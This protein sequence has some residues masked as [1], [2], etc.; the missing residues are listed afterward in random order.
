MKI[1]APVGE[2]RHPVQAVLR[3][4]GNVVPLVIE[5]EVLVGS[6]ITRKVLKRC[7]ICGLPTRIVDALA[8]K[9]NQ[10]AVTSK[11][12]LLI[13]TTIAIPYLDGRSVGCLP[14]RQV[15]ALARIIYWANGAICSHVP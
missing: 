1:E 8:P 9:S 12:P 7:S 15:Q 10:L 11:R 6:S 3:H 5:H 2:T 4:S 13:G 14:S